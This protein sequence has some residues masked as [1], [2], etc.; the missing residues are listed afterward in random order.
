M[1]KSTTPKLVLID[2]KGKKII[3]VLSPTARTTRLV[4]KYREKTKN[5]KTPTQQQP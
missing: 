3:Y 1:N 5:K 2:S 4:R